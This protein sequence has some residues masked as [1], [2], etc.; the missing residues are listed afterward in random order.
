M[1]RLTTHKASPL[2]L[3]RIV[4]VLLLLEVGGLLSFVFP[5]DLIL[6]LA[7]NIGSGLPTIALRRGI[8]FPSFLL[9]IKRRYCNTPGNHVPR[10]PHQN[11]LKN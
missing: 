1:T 3:I 2:I 6:G 5:L 11:T 10:M 4:V 9:N 8:F 7:H